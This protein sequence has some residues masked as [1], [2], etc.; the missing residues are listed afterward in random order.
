MISFK[1]AAKYFYQQFKLWVKAY[2]QVADV[3]MIDESWSVGS[4]CYSVTHLTIRASDGAIL[5]A[6]SE[7]VDG[8]PRH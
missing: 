3:Y 6:K 8:T 1:A 5:S 4:S 7:I 2:N